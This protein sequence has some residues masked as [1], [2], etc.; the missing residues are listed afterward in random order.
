MRQVQSFQYLQYLT[1][2]QNFYN[3]ITI[4]LQY[5]YNSFI[6]LLQYRYNTFTILEQQLYN[7]FTILLHY[8][9]NTFTTL[10]QYFYNTFTLLLQYFHNTFTILI[11]NFNLFYRYNVKQTVNGKCIDFLQIMFN[12][13]QMYPLFV[14]WRLS[15]SSGVLRSKFLPIGLLSVALSIVVAT[16]ACVATKALEEQTWAAFAIL[17]V[18]SIQVFERLQKVGPI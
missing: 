1:P 18:V 12:F 11:S 16:I 17:L 14:C 4:I 3:T 10:L 13:S 2:L 9:Y 6:I 7:T 8:F 15:L 5:F